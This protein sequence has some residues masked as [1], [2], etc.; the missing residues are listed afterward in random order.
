MK[1]INDHVYSSNFNS[2]VI[3]FKEN[4]YS[5]FT[6]KDT[7]TGMAYKGL[8]V[9]DLSVLSLTDLPLLVHDSVV[10]KQISDEAIERIM[11]LYCTSNKQVIIALDKQNSYG[12]KTKKV[13]EENA[14]LYL[15]PDT[16][17]LFGRSW[18]KN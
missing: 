9:F 13:L 18:G 6:P 2:P 7:G 4:T 8:V 14:I 16:G 11:E 3:S 5:F 17:A 12:K 10:L 15:S 1:E